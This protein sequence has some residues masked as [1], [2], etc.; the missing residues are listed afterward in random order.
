MNSGWNMPDGVY[1]TP[2]DRAVRCDVCGDEIQVEQEIEIGDHTY[3]CQDCHEFM[4][5]ELEDDD[6]TD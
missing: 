4:I 3:I 2:Y 1:E 5:D 6:E